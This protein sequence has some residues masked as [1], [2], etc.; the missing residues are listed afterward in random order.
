MI[1]NFYVEYS[2]SDNAFVESEKAEVE[3]SHATPETDL[4]AYDELEALDEIIV[5]M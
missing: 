1:E 4:D 3:F 2:S 5:G